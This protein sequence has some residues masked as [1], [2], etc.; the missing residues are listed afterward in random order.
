MLMEGTGSAPVVHKTSRSGL[1]R[2]R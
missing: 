2:Q 1:T